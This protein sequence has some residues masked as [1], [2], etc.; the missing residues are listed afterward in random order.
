[1]ILAEKCV[2]N[3]ISVTRYDCHCLQLSFLVGTIIANFI[4]C[5]APRSSLSAGE[6]DAFYDKIISLVAAV[7]DEEMILI[8]G[9]FNGLVREHSA[10]F[11]GIHGGNGYAVINQ[12]ELQILDFC[13]VNKLAVA[14]TF[15]QM[16]VS[17]LITY[18]FGDTVK[19]VQTT[20]SIRPPLV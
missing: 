17:R 11:E 12:D 3:V 19:L 14:K 5:Y 4:N 18:S 7:L 13:V 9:D 16:N 6:K 1:M 8:G 10:V 15:F 20:T 2:N